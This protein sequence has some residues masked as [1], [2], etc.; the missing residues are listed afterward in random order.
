MLHELNLDSP[1]FRRVEHG[2]MTAVIC[3]HHRDYQAGDTLNLFEAHPDGARLRHYVE[4]LNGRFLHEWRDNTPITVEI[5]HVLSH[6]QYPH[7][8]PEGF[9]MLSFKLTEDA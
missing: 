9:C 4:R 8:L 3:K 2:E 1:R 5:T 6:H 7:A